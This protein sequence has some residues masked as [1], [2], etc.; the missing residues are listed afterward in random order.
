MS[1]VAGSTTATGTGSRNTDGSAIAITVFSTMRWWGR[2]WLTVVF[3]L[4]RWFPVV[5]TQ[6]RRLS[7][8][9]FARWTIVREIPHNGAP[10]PVEAL[11]YPHLFFESNFNGGWEEYIDAFS[12][13]LTRGMGAFWRN[14]YGYPGALPTPPFKAYIRANEIEAEHFYSAYP[15]A[16]ATMITSALMLDD[17]VT[18]LVTA[19]RGM[20]AEDFGTAWTG[21]LTR[22]QK[23]L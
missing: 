15:E 4:A 9:H 3:H 1:A 16:T 13:I 11:N 10:Q 12:Y 8:I 5:L 2:A 21:F 23:S 6:L 17:E 20:T 7:F 22:V 19:A 18:A 14:S